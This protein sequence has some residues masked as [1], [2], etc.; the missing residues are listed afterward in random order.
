MEH[1]IENLITILMVLLVVIV[2]LS[3]AIAGMYCL[4]RAVDETAPTRHPHPAE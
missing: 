3:I 2:G 1:L 4:D